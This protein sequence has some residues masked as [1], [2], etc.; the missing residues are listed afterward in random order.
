MFGIIIALHIGPPRW[1]A[2][3]PVAPRL[4]NPNFKE[5]WVTERWVF[6]APFAQPIVTRDYEEHIPPLKTPLPNVYMGNMFQVYP[7][8][9]GQNYSIKLANEMVKMVKA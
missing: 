9:R 8:D 1:R 7:Q 4:R 5:D 3:G 2:K 6:K